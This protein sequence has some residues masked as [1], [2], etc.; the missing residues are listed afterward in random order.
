MKES[1][2]L[3]M[4][5]GMPVLGNTGP[6]PQELIDYDPD[7]KLGYFGSFPETDF[8]TIN[9]ITNDSGLIVGLSN[10]TAI[11]WMKFYYNKRILFISQKPIKYNLS[12]EDLLNAGLLDN[13]QYLVFNDNVFKYTLLSGLKVNPVEGFT[14]GINNNLTD[15]SEYSDILYSVSSKNYSQ[16]KVK[17]ESFTDAQLGIGT[18]ISGS[19]NWCLDEYFNNRNEAI[20]RGY[21]DLGYVSHSD[22]T[23]TNNT[24]GYRIVLELSNNTINKA[25]FK[26]IS[27]NVFEAQ[28]PGDFAIPSGDF[29][30]GVL[31]QLDR[32]SVFDAQVPGDFAIPSGNFTVS[33]LAQLDRP[34][35]FPYQ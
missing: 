23:T 2:L 32:P 35:P 7:T 20:S 26:S 24:K 19:E 5:T 33:V 9:K 10:S 30:V 6:G 21:S 4:D 18:S 8:V 27:S 16:T 11:T 15:G 34:Y 17:F 28:V 31:A 22:K 29:T 25:W 13:G 3:A 1:F 12:Y 14:N